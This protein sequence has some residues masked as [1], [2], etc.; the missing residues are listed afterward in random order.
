MDPNS[1]TKGAIIGCAFLYHVKVYSNERGMNKKTKYGF[2]HPI[3]MPGQRGF[4]EVPTE[5]IR[6]RLNTCYE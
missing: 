3:F 6:T 1:L 5:P 2:L 4:F